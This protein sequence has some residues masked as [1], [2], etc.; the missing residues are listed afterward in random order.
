MT[1]S[2]DLLALTQLTSAV[3]STCQARMG[4]LR[5]AEQELRDKLEALDSARKARSLSLTEADTA[6]QA[7][8]DLLWQSWIEQRRAALNTALSRILLAQEAARAALA[9]AFGRDQ[10][11]L[12]LCARATT[13]RAKTKARRDDATS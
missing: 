6:L 9:L 5:Q 10:A 4:A 11:T 2:H 12:G 13:D 8:A 7:G 1:S 3:F